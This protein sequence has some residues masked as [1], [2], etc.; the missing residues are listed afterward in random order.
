[1]SVNSKKIVALILAAGESSRLGKPKQNLIYGNNT[2]LN[3]IKEH[4]TLN[5]VD[6]TFIVLGAYSKEIIRSSKLNASE[7]IE[8]DN[9]KEGMGS[10]LAYACSKIFSEKDYDGILITLSDLPLVERSDY[11]KMIDL[12]ESDFD[13]VATKANKSLG[14]PAI[15]GAQY[16]NELQQIKGKKGAKP[17]INKYKKVAKVY[18]NNNAAIDVDSVSDYTKLLNNE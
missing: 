7:V 8:F 16:F 15:F 4:L 9:W 17:L 14:V 11:E 6:R 18:K 2:L 12:F 5:F 13:I 3:H 10:S 1:M